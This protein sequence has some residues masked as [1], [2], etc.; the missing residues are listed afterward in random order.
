MATDFNA[1]INELQDKIDDGQE[2][3][4]QQLAKGN[5]E[6]AAGA[7]KKIALYEA[8]LQIVNAKRYESS[9]KESGNEAA[10][11][12]AAAKIDEYSNEYQ[13]LISGSADPATED[14]ATENPAPALTNNTAVD[15]ANILSDILNSPLYTEEIKGAWLS[16]YLPGLTRA[17]VQINAAQAKEVKDAVRRD[18]AQTEAIREVAGN[19]AARGMR[20]P[21]MANRGFAPI[22][23][24]TDAAEDEAG[25]YIDSLISNKEV[26]YGAGTEDQETFM[27]DPNM[28]GSVG[29]TARRDAVSGLTGLVSQ[30]KLNQVEE[31]PISPLV[32]STSDGVTSDP[33]PEATN[34]PTP[35][36]APE[37]TTTSY[38]IKS[39]DTLGAIAKKYKTTVAALAKQ[40]NIANPN[41]IYAGS[42]LKIG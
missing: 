2:Y 19:Y 28:F 33:T 6:T 13:D 30:Y 11:Q 9:M 7:A 21:E 38:K 3:Y 42:S 4:S 29:A 17:N 39:G 12:S 22:Q 1:Y 23:R 15:Q 37:T 24:D 40:N 41:L 34:D 18:Q 14:P 5:S 27:S 35:A 36:P 20:T 32:P 26:M 25:A 16:Q 10:A 8:Q 31:A